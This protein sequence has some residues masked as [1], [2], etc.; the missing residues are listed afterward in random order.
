MHA[1]PPSKLAQKVGS[2]L[3][4]VVLPLLLFFSP[5]RSISP[6]SPLPALALLSRQVQADINSAIARGV[7]AFQLPEGEI[8]FNGAFF[9]ID[10]ATNMVRAACSTAPTERGERRN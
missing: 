5:P 9:R 8:R 1:P 2:F 10:N 7:P 3:L 4:F 6:L